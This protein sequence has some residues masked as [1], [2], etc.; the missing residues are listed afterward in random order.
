MSQQV[1]VN[2]RSITNSLIIASFISVVSMIP[3]AFGS[4]AQLPE[5]SKPMLCG[6]I[7]KSIG[8]VQVL[9]ASRTQVLDSMPKSLL[10]C[11]AWLSVG[12]QAAVVVN[13][14][15]GFTV[16]ASEGAF[17]Q[18]SDLNDQIVLYRGELHVLADSGDHEIRIISPNARARLKSGTMI[19]L[20]NSEDE[21]TQLIVLEKTASLENRYQS[22]RSV[23]VREGEASAL[24]FKLERVVPSIPRAVAVASLKKKLSQ[25][26]VSE[27][28]ESVALQNAHLRQTRK[29]A[30][31]STGEDDDEMKA[32]R[33]KRSPA[34]ENKPTVKL[35]GRYERHA[36]NAKD[37][38]G[39]KHWKGRMLAGI[40]DKEAEN[41][42]EPGKH[43]KKKITVS[44]PEKQKL[45]E[46]KARLLEE[47]SKVRSD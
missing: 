26:N 4:E 13:L 23:L 5:T 40:S 24:N 29:F 6:T 8:Q 25:F 32:Y 45:D 2:M 28:E 47:L 9:D 30:D 39:E 38:V 10:P 44:D 3:Q 41:L 7:K 36:K 33:E 19:V 12:S 46:E 35:N 14:K 16:H 31:S 21:E 11:G 43:Q 22:Q 20:Y 27:E 42:M 37:P 18:V 15:E 17:F 34:S 1:Q